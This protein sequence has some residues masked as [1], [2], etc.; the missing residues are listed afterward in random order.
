MA[1]SDTPKPGRLLSLDFLRGYFVLVIIIDHLW[2][3]PSAWALVSGEAK[4]WVT[5]AEGFVIISGF[6]IGYVRGFKGLKL[7][8]LTIAKKLFSRAIMLYVWTIFISMGYIWIEWQQKVPNMPYTDFD[9][10][11]ATGDYK[12]ALWHVISGQPHAWIHFL[13][14]YAIFLIIAIGAVYLFRK[15]LSWL[16]A[17]FSILLYGAGVWQDIEWMKWQIIFFLP[18]LAGFHFEAIRA[19]WHNYAK[20]ERSLAKR[21]VFFLAGVTLF[22]S[23]LTTYLPQYFSAS[24]N[25]TISDMFQVEY[26]TPARIA[27]AMLWFI[28]LA[29]IFDK[30][31]PQIQKYTRGVLEYMGNHSLTVYIAHGYVIVLVNYLLPTTPPSYL[32]LVY[33]TLLGAITLAGVYLVIRLPVLRKILPR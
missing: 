12:D 11:V 22:M 3:F 16:V 2:R 32:E 27:V 15:R 26:F 20:D 28:A 5:A 19:K 25:T 13:Y 4:L 8:F 18:S 21:L 33:N 6:L 10:D 24:V 9:P 17:I 1:S 7:P 29:F 30:F 23:I 14:L 31:T